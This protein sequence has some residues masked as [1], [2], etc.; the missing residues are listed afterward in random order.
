MSLATSAN[1]TKCVPSNACPLMMRAK[2]IR[3]ERSVHDPSEKYPPFCALRWPS[4][5]HVRAGR[6]FDNRELATARFTRRN[7]ARVELR[8]PFVPDGPPR[9]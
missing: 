5:P 7:A 3:H 4:H 9:L 2:R 8:Y 6:V 1:G